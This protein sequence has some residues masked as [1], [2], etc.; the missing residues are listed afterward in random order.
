MN[1]IYIGNNEKKVG[2]VK[3]PNRYS[4]DNPDSNTGTCIREKRSNLYSWQDESYLFQDFSKDA[5]CS[6]KYKNILFIG[7]S[8][9]HG[10]F[11]SLT[12]L[13][14]VDYK[15]I[16]GPKVSFYTNVHLC[17]KNITFIRNDILFDRP[18]SLKKENKICLHFKNEMKEKDLLI[19]NRGVHYSP[20]EEVI[21]DLYVF[22]EKY[23][24]F[25][26]Q[27]VIYRETVP[28][29]PNCDVKREP[30]V[31]FDPHYTTKEKTEWNWDKIDRQNS[32][33]LTFIKNMFPLVRL[34]MVGKMTKLRSD[35][36]IGHG[37]CIHYCLPGPM[38]HWN[39]MLLM[40]IYN[41]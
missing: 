20:T 17:G 29:H 11:M 12:F 21:K 22:F 24:D 15:K 33:V 9:T 13:L 4:Y 16:T 39:K 34:L 14:G 18:C 37:D 30:D 7:D 35:M 5:F 27:T 23:V 32:E 6:T 40:E 31:I 19:V 8:T 10:Q 3:S 38:D 25:E 26:R 28:G 36:H 41:D 1:K 2:W